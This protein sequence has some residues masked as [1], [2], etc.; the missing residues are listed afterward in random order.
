MNTNN[1]NEQR[2]TMRIEKLK[3]Q[4]ARIR[5]KKTTKTFNVGMSNFGDKTSESN[6]SGFSEEKPVNLRDTC[7]SVD[8]DKQVIQGQGREEY[9]IVPDGHDE[10]DLTSALECSK[11]LPPTSASVLPLSHNNKYCLRKS[12]S[13]SS[14]TSKQRRFLTYNNLLM[15]NKNIRSIAKSTKMNAM[16]SLCRKIEFQKKYPLSSIS[17]TIISCQSAINNNKHN[18]DDYYLDRLSPTVIGGTAVN[19]NE[20]RKEKINYIKLINPIFDRNAK[21]ESDANLRQRCYDGTLPTSR[22]ATVTEHPADQNKILLKYSTNTNSS[23]TNDDKLSTVNDSVAEQW[24]T[25]EG[26]GDKINTDTDV[27]SG[28]PVTESDDCRIISDAQSPDIS[29]TH[30]PADDNNGNLIIADDDH[31]VINDNQ[32]TFGSFDDDQA[33]DSDRPVLKPEPKSSWATHQSTFCEFKTPDPS[34]M[35]HIDDRNRSKGNNPECYS[36]VSKCNIYYVSFTL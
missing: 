5:A 35:M 24:P 9:H 33:A 2:L 1:G 29:T 13:F 26:G 16:K 6:L 14:L 23:A 32:Q 3:L 28:E 12:K 11:L 10:V 19:N 27:G 8:P 25:I 30:E 31:R 15:K 7:G 17:S 21:N 18:D 20:K 34:K 36:N 22:N 4:L